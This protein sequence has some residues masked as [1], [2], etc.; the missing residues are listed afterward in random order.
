MHSLIRYLAGEELLIGISINGS[1]QL[2][3]LQVVLKHLRRLLNHKLKL[4][5]LIVQ[6]SGVFLKLVVIDLS[7]GSQFIEKLLNSHLG[8]VFNRNRCCFL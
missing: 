4:R 2:C 3:C 6:L 5:L 7:H 8:L 1:Q